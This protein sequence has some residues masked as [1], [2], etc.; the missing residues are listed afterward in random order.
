MSAEIQVH[1]ASWLVTV[2]SP[3]LADAGLV[4]SRGRII[5]TGSR[6]ELLAH[7]PQA[8]ETRYDQA[9][10]TPALINAH[11]HL[12][13]SHLAELGRQTPPASFTAWIKKM[14]AL[15]DL[16]QQ[17][18]PNGEKAKQA[19]RETV[20]ALWQDGVSVLADIGNTLIGRELA[21]K[22]EALLLPFKEYLGLFP[23]ALPKQLRRLQSEAKKT[24]CS[25]HALYSTHPQLLQAV[26]QRARELGQIFPIHTAEPVAE[27]EMLRHGRGE[28]VDFIRERGFW[29]PA[30]LPEKT[31]G[32]VHY[33]HELGLL[34]EKTLCVHAI[35]V[36][37][38]ETRILADKGVKI[39]LCPGSNRFLGVGR[40]PLRNYLAHGLR[41]ALGTDSAAS[42]PELSLWRE[43]ALLAEDHPEVDAAEIFAMASLN[44]AIALR[45]DQRLGSLEAGKDAD[46]LV[47]QVPQ[48]INKAA[49]VCPA[50]VRAW[51]HQQVRHIR[52]PAQ[53]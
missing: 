15:R 18:D 13:L 16:Y 24:L 25:G 14:L 52:M 12:E 35:H 21:E 46:F 39:C 37:A 31:R 28:M 26:K 7:Y 40:A 41:P 36:D 19:A 51:P 8:Q 4:I 32:S 43:M 6:A 42:N 2:K 34:D 29:D 33:L 49:E 22:S 11:I 48:A 44:G 30:V 5:Q 9:I 23:A 1:T 27:G 53:Q 17:G 38:E 10:L 45:L 47:V 3:P 20:A 50:L